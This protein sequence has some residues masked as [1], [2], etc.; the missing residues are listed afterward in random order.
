[1]IFS[2]C[3]RSTYAEC[4]LSLCK[5]P[6]YLISFLAAGETTV[7]HVVSPPESQNIWKYDN[8]FYVSSKL[9]PTFIIMTFVIMFVYNLLFIYNLYLYI[10]SSLKYNVILV[11]CQLYNYAISCNSVDCIV[12]ML[13]FTQKIKYIHS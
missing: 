7:T 5:C 13:H 12:L 11:L 6:L 2:H 1:M 10:I 3:V 4:A 9:L 8:S